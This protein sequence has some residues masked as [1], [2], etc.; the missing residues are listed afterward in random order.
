MANST[1]KRYPPLVLTPEEIAWFVTGK[2]GG[3]PMGQSFQPSE[4]ARAIAIILAESGGN[5]YALNSTP[6][7]ESYG[8]AQINMYGRLGPERR[9]RYKLQSNEDLYQADLNIAIMAH[10]S[11]A[12]SDW[13]PWTTYVSGAYLLHMGRAQDAVNVPKDPGGKLT[14]PEQAA[15]NAS[16]NPLEKLMKWVQDGVL[17][18]AGFVGGGVLLILAIVLYVRWQAN[19]G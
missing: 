12:G 15:A 7:D 19:R 1:P 13:K 17:R 16:S 3:L 11:G 9:E 10:M 14:T 6:P 8:L 4:Y 18:I 2:G 5:T